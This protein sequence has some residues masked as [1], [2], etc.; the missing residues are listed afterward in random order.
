[1]PT[2]D[3]SVAMDD[4][5]T[6]VVPGT[7]DTYTIT[8]TNNGPDTLSSL[9]LSDAVPPTLANGLVA[10]TPSVGTYDVNTHIWSGLSLAS[11][12]SVSFT[13][14][15]T[16]DPTA[17]GSLTNN[18]LV[19]PPSGTSDPN[20][21]NNS[22]SDTDT[23]T[24]QA[25]L[26]VTVSDG[27]TTVVPGTGDTYTITVTNNGPSTVS[28][29]T[30]TD[31]IP[32]ALLN[33]IF[34]PSAGAYDVGTGVWSGLALASGQ[35]VTITLTGTIDPNAAGTLANTVT[36][37]PPAG[38]TDPT[39]ANNTATDTD[40]TPAADLSVTVTDGKTTVAP[41]DIDTYTITVTNNGPD[42]LSSL[43]LI[44]AVALSSPIFGLPSAGRYNPLTGAWTGLSPGD[45]PDREPHAQR[46]GHPE[47]DRLAHQHRRGGPA[48][49]H[50]RHQP[51]Q[52]CRQ[53]H[54]H[55][56]SCHQPE[57]I[58][59]SRHQRQYDSAPRRRP[60]CDLRH[61]QQRDLGRL[62][63]GPGGNRLAVCRPRRL[64]SP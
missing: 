57:P 16:I 12:Q 51:R 56:D 25:D 21:T 8:V 1:M 22:A 38:T 23:L 64:P 50:E 36:V 39:P 41:G 2:A 4:G 58:S 30:L 18:V 33:P 63:V 31:A 60:V 29:L 13:V 59:T 37:A 53:R 42:T 7:T 47:R 26:S 49:R 48:G 62:S 27:K 15:G 52:Q 34:A 24:P 45:R 46:R 14:L 19:L 61:R 10:C 20:I 40:M 3:L 28:S 11:G 43:T 5:K 55:G 17:T 54:R 32:A 44:E 9:I 6:T 35:N